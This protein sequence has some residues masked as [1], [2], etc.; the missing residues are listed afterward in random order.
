MN[1]SDNIATL[2]AAL[3][4][5]QNELGNP[6]NNTKNAFLGNSYF[7]LPDLIDHVK[8][9]LKAHGLTVVQLPTGNGGEAGIST[10]ILHQSG[11]WISDTVTMPIEPRKGN[12]L[13]QVAGGTITYLRRYSL[14]AALNIASEDDD[15]NH[16]QDPRREQPKQEPKS[17]YVD[18]SRMNPRDMSAKQLAEAIKQEAG[19][20]EEWLEA[21]RQAWDEKDKGRLATLLAEIRAKRDGA[22]TEEELF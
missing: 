17:E 6:T 11:E 3:V 16:G 14:A 13:A 5:A 10:T 15:G 8:S 22:A 9:V 21:A 12:T 4:A 1:H 18:Y 2:A 20:N 7:P 19:D